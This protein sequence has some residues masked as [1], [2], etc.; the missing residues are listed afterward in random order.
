[1]NALTPVTADGPREGSVRRLTVLYD[2]TCATCLKWAAW[3]TEQRSLVRLELLPAGSKAAHD[4]FP[5]VAAWLGRELVVVDDR[6]RAW[7][8][9]PA[10]VM[11]LWALARFRW[12]ASLAARPLLAPLATRV[13]EHISN[14]RRR[15]DPT[16]AACADRLQFRDKWEV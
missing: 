12:A 2:E 5:H 1:M 10:F 8:G 4:Q 7:I 13:F 14:R 16:C 9:P 3:L 15:G 11:C 6:A